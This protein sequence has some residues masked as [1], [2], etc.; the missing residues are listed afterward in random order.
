LLLRCS[1]MWL[2]VHQQ[3]VPHTYCSKRHS[4]HM[5]KAAACS[6]VILQ[7]PNCRSATPAF[8]GPWQSATV[9]TTAGH[10]STWVQSTPSIP[11]HEIH[12]NIILP[13][14]PSSSERS[15]PFR[16][17]TQ[18]SERISHLAHA[19]YVPGQLTARPCITFSNVLL[20]MYLMRSCQ[21]QPNPKQV[22]RPLSA[23]HECLSDIFPVPSPLKT[24]ARPGHDPHPVPQLP[25]L[26]TDYPNIP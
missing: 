20:L 11:F 25:T 1:K 3:F 18:D 8:H 26:T 19:R 13:S 5:T 2:C 12:C 10:R 15:L 9:L 21:T 4:R 17:S 22:D 14:K 24:K 7:Q 6:S 16:N 23:V